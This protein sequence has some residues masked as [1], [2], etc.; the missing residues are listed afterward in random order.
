M[1]MSAPLRVLAPA[2]VLEILA[3][4]AVLFEEYVRRSGSGRQGSVRGISIA[5]DKAIR[6]YPRGDPGEHP[7]EQIGWQG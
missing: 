4:K 5:L 2:G 3:T 1:N 7:F 6:H